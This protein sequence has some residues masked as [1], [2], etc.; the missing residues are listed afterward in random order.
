MRKIIILIFVTLL[1]GCSEKK[2]NFDFDRPEWHTKKV[3]PAQYENFERGKTYLPI[4]SHIYHIE[5]KQNYLLAVT[6]SIRNISQTDTVY[7]L[8]GDYYNT[9]GDKIQNYVPYPVFV[10]PMETI[11]IVIPEKDNPGGSGANFVFEWAAENMKNA[12][13][14]EAIMISTYGQQGLSFTSRG[15]RIYE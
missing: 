2:S 6:V 12:P 3:L 15:V 8:M 1:F 9:E 7:V 10:M 13:L 4:Y 5:D 14:F 11:E